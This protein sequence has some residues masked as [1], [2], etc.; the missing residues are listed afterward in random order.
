MVRFKNFG[1]VYNP[2]PNLYGFSHTISS[3]IVPKLLRLLR[4]NPSFKL[5]KGSRDSVYTFVHAT[6]VPFIFCFFFLKSSV[7]YLL[8]RL[9][10]GHRRQAYPFTVVL[11]L[12]PLLTSNSR[13]SRDLHIVLLRQPI[14]SRLALPTSSCS[15]SSLA[16]VLI[17]VVFIKLQIQRRERL[18]YP[19][20]TFYVFARHVLDV[21]VLFSLTPNILDLQKHPRESTRNLSI[22]RSSQVGHST[23]TYFIRR[24][25]I[26]LASYMSTKYNRR[27]DI[28]Y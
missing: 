8:P 7:F 3:L 22:V 25:H 2:G 17:L 14:F 23:V 1:L 11:H 21:L 10:V 9:N 6:F 5:F 18:I 15:E 19:M 26:L 28:F 12:P 16:V 20:V 4:H 24:L 13:A 27:L